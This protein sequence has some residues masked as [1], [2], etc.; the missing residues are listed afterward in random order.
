MTGKLYG[1]ILRK[2]LMEV[3]EGKNSE[4]QGCFRKS[5]IVWIEHLQLK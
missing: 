2:K 5:K 1:R 3:T 4:E